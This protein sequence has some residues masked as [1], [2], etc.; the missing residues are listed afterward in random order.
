MNVSV[1]IPTR[2]SARWVG[3]FLAAYR[4]IGIEPFYIVDT[5]SK[6]STFDVL[7][8]M[9]ARVIPFTPTCDYVEAGMIEFGATQMPTKWVIRID[10]DEFPTRGLLKWAQTVAAS[11]LDQ[12]W[13]LSRRELFFRD[14]AIVY[15]RASTRYMNGYRP[16][17][18][19]PQMRMF[20][21]DRVRFNDKIHG[22][23]FDDPLFFDFAPADIYLIHL[24]CLLRSP[25]ERLQKIT[26]YEDIAPGSSSG[27]A[28]LYLP[29]LFSDTHHRSACDGLKQFSDL[30]NAIPFAEQSVPTIHP[31]LLAV[32]KRAVQLNAEHLASLPL[33]PSK[34]STHDFRW[35]KHI[36][37]ACR[38]EVAKGLSTFGAKKLSHGIWAYLDVME[39]IKIRT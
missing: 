10:D 22:A 9:G 1:F 39:S 34:L 30:L 25:T 15:S 24:D 17:F 4:E 16:D 38:R 13:S 31:D 20:N 7:R 8:T 5:R 29:E 14:G 37:L 3:Q 18:L 23:G 32:F 21:T 6:D 33:P 36:P 11:S 2:D 19:H 28:D 35:L 26:R 27:L 12:V